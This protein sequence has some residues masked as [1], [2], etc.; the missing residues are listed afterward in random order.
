VRDIAWGREASQGAGIMLETMQCDWN[1]VNAEFHGAECLGT[2]QCTKNVSETI[3][4]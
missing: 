4:N 3:S 2:I 1:V